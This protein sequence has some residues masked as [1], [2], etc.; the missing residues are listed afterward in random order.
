MSEHSHDH[1]GRDALDTAAAGQSGDDFASWWN[2]QLTRREASRR[3]AMMAASVVAGG[4]MACDSKGSDQVGSGPPPVTVREMDSL[5]AQQEAGWTV[6]A[7]ANLT[8]EA[9]SDVDSLGGETWRE[10]TDPAALTAAT[11]PRRED[12]AAHAVSTLFQALGQESLQ[13]QIRPIHTPEM[14]A[15]YAAGVSLSEL[16]YSTEEPAKT[17]IIVDAPGPLAVA[18]AAGMAEVAEPAF[19]FDNWPHPAGVVPSDQTLAA[20]LYYAAELAQSREARPEDAPLVLVLDA[21]RLN[22]YNNESNRFDNRYVAGVPDVERLA[23]LGIERVLYLTGSSAQT[24]ESDDLNQAMVAWKEAGLPVDMLSI[25]AFGLD[26]EAPPPPP[27]VVT[28]TQSTEPQHY[29]HHYHYYGGSWLTHMYFFSYYGAYRYRER[30]RYRHQS[31]YYT[32]SPG[33]PA[34]AQSGAL[35]DARAPA[36][37][38][39]SRPTYTPATRQTRFSARYTGGRAGVGVSRPS[40]FGRVS[41]RTD[42][43]GRILGTASRS[44]QRTRTRSSTPRRSSPSR[45]RSGSSGRSRGG[46]RA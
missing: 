26:E 28:A 38:R 40:G 43:S 44:A 5:E 29:R 21:N 37:G 10:Y 1:D 39:L 22:P 25:D 15:A 18:A 42:S 32:R 33:V 11:L 6:G 3:L 45:R 19:F 46:R 36:E 31:W 17:L 7:E 2:Q 20:V 9:A 4:A 14:D 27:E 13:S 16:I 34:G 41:V 12:W 8:L 35:V 30:P 24:Q 23:E